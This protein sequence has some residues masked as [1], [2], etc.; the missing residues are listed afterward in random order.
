M[1][2]G[3]VPDYRQYANYRITRSPVDNIP[4]TKPIEKMYYD[5]IDEE[6]DVNDDDWLEE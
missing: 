6:S 2:M 1:D 3:Q 5:P 4:K